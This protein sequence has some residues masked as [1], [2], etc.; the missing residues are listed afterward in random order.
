[1]PVAGSADVLIEVVG[2]GFLSCLTAN[3]DVR[4]SRNGDVSLA[5]TVDAYLFWDGIEPITIV[6]LDEEL[7]LSANVEIARSGSSDDGRLVSRCVDEDGDD[8]EGTGSA[9]LTVPPPPEVGTV[10][11]G[12]EPAGGAV[13]S[14]VVSAPSALDDAL[15]VPDSPDGG[16]MLEN[17]SRPSDVRIPAGKAGGVIGAEPALSGTDPMSWGLLVGGLLLVG[18]TLGVPLLIPSFLQA[19]RGPKWV[20]ANVRAVA[21]VAPAVGVE[22][23]PQNDDHWFPT[24]VVRFAVHADGGTQN[25]TEVKQ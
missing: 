8:D 5:A 16:S 19:R 18:A 11:P 23:A 25:L 6:H 15:L 9:D 14:P 2:D 1:M 17:P 20:R 3:G 12:G 4:S 24:S 22:L 21:Q 7:G 13:L 10:V